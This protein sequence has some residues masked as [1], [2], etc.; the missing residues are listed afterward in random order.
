MIRLSLWGGDLLVL[1]SDGAVSEETERLLAD[2]D[3][4]N[5]KELAARLT[6]LAKAAG[7]EDDMTAAVL[8]LDALT[9]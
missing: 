5:V 3:G 1:V 6:G 4:E 7:G 2:F 9:P 8:R